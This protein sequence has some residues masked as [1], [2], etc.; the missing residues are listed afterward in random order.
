[1][2]KQLFNSQTGGQSLAVIDLS[3]E[4]GTLYT[5]QV[6]G[7]TGQSVLIQGSNFG[8]AGPW[9]TITADLLFGT[10]NSELF[11]MSW[12]FMRI[13]LAGGAACCITVGGE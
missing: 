3:G 12:R 11:Y 2:I 13:D 5:A 9:E 6:T 10:K 4:N 8:A 1:M 7:T